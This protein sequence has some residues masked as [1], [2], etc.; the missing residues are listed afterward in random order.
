MGRLRGV[1]VLLAKNNNIAKYTDLCHIMH[2]SKRSRKAE[3]ALLAKL[4]V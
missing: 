2:T 1:G 4:V 3:K